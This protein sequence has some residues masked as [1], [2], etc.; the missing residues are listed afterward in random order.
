MASAGGIMPV[1]PGILFEATVQGFFQQVSVGS[2]EELMLWVKFTW[3]MKPINGLYDVK[4]GQEPFLV[5]LL[6]FF[7]IN[8]GYGKWLL[9]FEEKYL[10]AS[11]E[12]LLSMRLPLRQLLHSC[13]VGLQQC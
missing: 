2:A 9:G 4:F 5:I 13:A 3:Y 8:S 7:L 1:K 6:A 12:L 10:W 11:L